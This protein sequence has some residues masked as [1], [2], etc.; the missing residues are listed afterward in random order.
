[1]PVLK[2]FDPQNLLF[3]SA[4]GMCSES[5]FGL[6][7]GGEKVKSRQ[8]PWAA[9]AFYKE[10]FYCGGSL[11]TKKCKKQNYDFSYFFFILIFFQ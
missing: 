6:I 11:S 10:N 1:M 2:Y 7:S 5:G 4:D 3:I 9:A 8:Y